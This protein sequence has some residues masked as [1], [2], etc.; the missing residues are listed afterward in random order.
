M[1][2]TGMITAYVYVMYLYEGLAI[3]RL[4]YL[5]RPIYTT[6]NYKYVNRIKNKYSMYA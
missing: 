6:Y 1:M 2:I 3:S 4:V 5:D